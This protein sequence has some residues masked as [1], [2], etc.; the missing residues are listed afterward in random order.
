MIVRMGIL[1]KKD[2]LTS[3]SFRNHWRDVHGPIAA[4]IGGLRR[5]CQNHVV[6]AMQRGFSYPRGP[7]VIDGFS[8]LW[9]DDLASMQGTLDPHT[10]KMLADDEA[11]FIGNL[12]LIVAEQRIVIPVA[13]GKPLLKRM[14]TIKR[15][16]DISPEKF[17]R[18]WFEVH[19]GLVK[20]LPQ[21][22]G[23]TQ[24]MIIE[25]A[26]ENGGK[27]AAL[28]GTYDDIPIDGIVELWFE[29]ITSLEAAFAS[30]DG[31]ILMAH[32]RE[33]IAEISTFVVET[34]E[35]IEAKA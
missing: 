26:V 11:N 4:Q 19:A 1:R 15:R 34:H 7:E 9:F 3:T 33:F 10:C 16:A 22:L 5:Y 12:K 20:K 17:Q 24:N 27:S 23:Y 2:G 6:D 18:E 30:P 32:A 13:T 28:D 14:S 29:D 21:V 25:R 8:Q 35:V 31:Q